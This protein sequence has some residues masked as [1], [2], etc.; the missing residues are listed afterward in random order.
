MMKINTRIVKGKAFKK[1]S[2]ENKVAAARAVA[3]KISVAK[4]LNVQA[5]VE[6]DATSLTAEAIMKGQEATP[7]QLSVSITF[8]TRRC[9][10]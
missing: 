9:V 6:K 2:A 8:Y 5:P 1:S 10:I 3:E 4:Q 7:L